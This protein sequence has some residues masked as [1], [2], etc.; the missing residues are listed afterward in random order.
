MAMKTLPVGGKSRCKKFVFDSFHSKDL[1][2]WVKGLALE[3]GNK[4]SSH[5][6][7]SIQM[8][9][10]RKLM[11]IRDDKSLQKRKFEHY[12]DDGKSTCTFELLNK[13]KYNNQVAKNHRRGESSSLSC[14][15]NSKEKCSFQRVQEHVAFH[16]SND[17]VEHCNSCWQYCSHS[18][19]S[20]QVIKGQVF[21]ATDDD[22]NCT[23]CC[24]DYSH[25]SDF[26]ESMPSSMKQG[27]LKGHFEPFED[28]SSNTIGISVKEK[29]NIEL[30]GELKSLINK[31]FDDSI[32]RNSYSLRL[33]QEDW[34]IDHPLHFH[35]NHCPQVF[36]PVGP[37]FQAEIPQC[38]NL[39]NRRQ[40]HLNDDF[41]WFCNEVWPMPVETDIKGVGNGRPDACSCDFPGSIDCVQLHISEARERLKLEIGT[42]FSSWKFD[43]MGEDVSKSWTIEEQKK[44]ES[45][46]RTLLSNDMD[47]WKVAMENFPNKP[48]KSM[49]N[50][51]YNVCIPRRM[52][53]ETRDSFVAIDSD[54]DKL[55][56]EDDYSTTTM[57]MVPICKLRKSR[58]TNSPLTPCNK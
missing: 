30:S 4:K 35:D 44:F 12:M 56:E 52:S 42:T 28:R 45:L 29:R 22:E 43:E 1:L 13:K 58:K 19:G 37:R 39:T 27:N 31:D 16:V 23:F 50:Y 26:D 6:R 47:F 55:M 2:I 8:L 7:L 34:K 53:R 25:L 49:L 48:M 32:S 15:G 3:P 46:T 11:N 51:Y 14:L 33:G 5:H 24:E 18:N 40:H 54:D 10:V 36:I 17:I 41:K 38:E 9:E 21:H 57:Q 20:S